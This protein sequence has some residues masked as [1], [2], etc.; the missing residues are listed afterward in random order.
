MALV[1]D[2]SPFFGFRFHY[3]QWWG[4]VLRTFFAQVRHEL[5]DGLQQQLV[6]GVSIHVLD[7]GIVICCP[8][9]GPVD[10]DGSVA[11]LF[12]KRYNPNAPNPFWW[13]RTPP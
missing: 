4:F 13:V 7:V 2:Q 11:G 1:V 12:Q 5:V 6:H 9:V 8:E 3:N 10:D